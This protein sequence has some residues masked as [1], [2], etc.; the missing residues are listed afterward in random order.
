MFL[1]PIPLKP[2]TNPKVIG[3]KVMVELDAKDFKR[4]VEHLKY[5]VLGILL[6]QRGD[7]VPTTR[8][9]KQNWWLDWKLK[10]YKR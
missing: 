1:D 9:K 3:G 4:R 6:L 2:I 10:I 8:R 5:K 7:S